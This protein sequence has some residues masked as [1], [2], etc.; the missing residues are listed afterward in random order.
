MSRFLPMWTVCNNPSDH[1]G[2][3]TAR[4]WELGSGGEFHV[5]DEV[6]IADTFAE[7]AGQVATREKRAMHFLP[8]KAADD[9]VIVGVLI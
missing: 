4:L 5:T 6:E 9:A 2:K 8:R 3:W 7:V 1:P